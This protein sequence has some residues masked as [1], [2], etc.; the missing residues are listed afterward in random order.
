MEFGKALSLKMVS[1]GG[2][3]RPRGSGEAPKRLRKPSRTAAEK[4][5]QGSQE[6]SSSGSPSDGDS[7][8]EDREADEG[9]A[10]T[11]NSHESSEGR[12]AHDDIAGVDGEQPVVGLKA[13]LDALMKSRPLAL[14]L[15]NDGPTMSDPPRTQ[16][17]V[18][19]AMVE[20]FLRCSGL[21]DLDALTFSMCMGLWRAGM[22]LKNEMV[23][24]SG[25]QRDWRSLC[26]RKLLKSNWAL[27]WATP[28]TDP[29][30]DRT[31]LF[32]PRKSQVKCSIGSGRVALGVATSLCLLWNMVVR[33]YFVEHPLLSSDGDDDANESGSLNEEQEIANVGPEKPP[34]ESAVDGPLPSP[35]VVAV[36]G[37]ADGGAAQ[38]GERRGRIAVDARVEDTG[39]AGRQAG[40]VVVCAKD[41]LRAGQRGDEAAQADAPGPQRKKHK[42]D[43]NKDLSPRP[44]GG[45]PP[46]PLVRRPKFGAKVSGAPAKHLSRVL[47]P[48][49]PPRGRR[50]APAALKFNLR[51]TVEARNMSMI[52]VLM[53]RWAVVATTRPDD[54]F[55]V[56]VC[57]ARKY[58]AVVERQEEVSL[59]LLRDVLESVG[60]NRHT[61]YMSGQSLDARPALDQAIVKV[62][63]KKA[64]YP[65]PYTAMALMAEI[66]RINE[67]YAISG[68]LS[69]WLEQL[70]S[71]R[72]GDCLVDPE[73][74]PFLMPTRTSVARMKVFVKSAFGGTPLLGVV[75]KRSVRQGNHPTSGDAVDVQNSC[76]LDGRTFLRAARTV[77]LQCSFVDPVLVELG[78]WASRMG[79]RVCVMTC[80]KLTSMLRTPQGTTTDLAD[81][82]RLGMRWAVGAGRCTRLATM[83]NH[84]KSHWSAAVIH[85][86]NRGIVYYD[87][88][89]TAAVNAASEFWLGR[90]R[91]LGSCALAVQAQRARQSSAAVEWVT[92]RVGFPLQPGTFSCGLFALQL[93]VQQVTGSTFD[94]VGAEAGLLRLVF[95]HAMA[96]AGRAPQD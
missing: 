32:P 87:S 9:A 61:I 89:A 41:V 48:L 56:R 82:K 80:E 69:L 58:A 84:D 90:R 55:S 63:V 29:L 8:D 73:H 74:N 50:M 60:K 86:T 45:D 19:T 54:G 81:A 93:L 20:R 25:V 26:P 64:T 70:G 66:H 46:A 91:L 14:S 18:T 53:N 62:S 78:S 49:A 65:V 35:P 31:C 88:L 79:N 96:L 10:A 24:S 92:C 52:A 11:L 44:R 17:P 5:R 51:R 43:F 33:R 2:G 42:L 12:D 95:L 94:L 57:G 67:D 16:E 1:T 68:Q 38:S 3:R 40:A 47:E 59:L 6:R 21:R 13:D 76:V 72:G 27:T 4:S 30:A 75:W 39:N 83:V 71:Q 28:Q 36:E 23:V 22:E 7:T 85:L 15:F 37:A 34:A 77:W